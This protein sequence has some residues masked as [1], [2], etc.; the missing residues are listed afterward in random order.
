MFNAIA[1]LFFLYNINGK[2]AILRKRAEREIIWD[3]EKLQL[4]WIGTMCY[5]I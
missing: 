1:V 3:Y 2:N 5:V 4:G